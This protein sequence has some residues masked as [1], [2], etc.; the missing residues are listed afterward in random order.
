MYGAGFVP[1]LLFYA[2]LVTY[3]TATPFRVSA[4][5]QGTVLCLV[6]KKDKDIEPSPV[7]HSSF[8]AGNTAFRK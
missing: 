5:R 7:F 2:D 3:S 4:L 6:D 8:S 1:A